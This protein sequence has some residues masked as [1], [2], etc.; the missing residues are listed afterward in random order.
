[1]AES[2]SG[3]GT[4]IGAVALPLVAVVFLGAQPLEI[5]FLEAALWSPWLLFGLLAGVVVDRSNQRYLMITC[6]AVAAVAYGAVPIIAYMQ[7]L[8]MPLLIAVALL[9]GTVN[10]F[11]QATRQTYPPTIVSDDKLPA[12]NSALEASGSVTDFAGAP[13]AGVLIQFAGAVAGVGVNA[14]SFVLSAF[15]LLI[16]PRSE[17]PAPSAQPEQVERV[18]LV[19]Q[20]TTGMRLVLDDVW[21]RGSATAAA[22]ANF[23]ITGVGTLQALFLVR[24]IG[25][26]P[27]WF[28][29]M[30]MGEGLGGFLGAIYA[31]RLASLLG[32]C[33]ALL[34]GA[35]FGPLLGSLVVFTH[36]GPSLA[37]FVV[38]S[39][40]STG[41][42][43]AGNVI[44]AIFRQRYIPAGLL[45]RTSSAVRVIAFC[46]AP[47]GAL[48][49]GVLAA[50]V[51]SRIA[52]LMLFACGL[53]RG[54][55]FL[56]AP[57]RT[58]RDLPTEPDANSAL[59]QTL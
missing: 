13:A 55:L 30:L 18:G 50:I 37:F 21:L 14:L 27:G 32:T 31:N 59:L 4:A 6:D 34:V 25:L 43:V 42:I 8:N 24:T 36:L 15:L 49:A 12:A 1:M 20:L 16:S 51:G 53:I 47:L 44:F 56:R 5:G 17:R 29:P 11:S 33:R 52:I 39:M 54:L 57:W 7:L 28:G 58:R 45:G 46:A 23:A 26:P 9:A 19:G 3:V 40:L 2:I 41:A 48:T 38:G 10:V 22:V 35:L